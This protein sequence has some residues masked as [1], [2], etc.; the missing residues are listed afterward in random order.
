MKEVNKSISSCK[1]TE[2]ME[3]KGKEKERQ[4]LELRIEI[5]D[6]N[7]GYDSGSS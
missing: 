3:A 1:R 5:N 2:E 7:N 4:I 6:R